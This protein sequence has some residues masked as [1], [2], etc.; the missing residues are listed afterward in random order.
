MKSILALPLG[1]SILSLVSASGTLQIGIEGKR[2]VGRNPLRRRDVTGTVQSTLSEHELFITYYANVTIGTPPQNIR[3]IV[4]T[5]SS[6]IW[7]VGA[8]NDVCATEAEGC[9]GGTCKL[10]D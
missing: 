4:D 7:T 1:L 3:L 2:E 8:G 10:V 9:P 6:D 5:G